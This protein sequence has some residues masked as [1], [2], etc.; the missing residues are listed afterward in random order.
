MQKKASERRVKVAT[1]AAKK[2]KHIAELV[3]VALVF[4][5]FTIIQQPA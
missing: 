3:N 4:D 5:R 1:R 2:A